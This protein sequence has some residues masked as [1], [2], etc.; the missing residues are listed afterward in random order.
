MGATTQQQNTQ[1]VQSTT[2]WAPAAGT[3]QGLLGNLSNINPNLTGA[4]TG[5]I[6]QLAALGQA[7]NPYTG[8]IGGVA[9]NLLGGG[10]AN[11]QGG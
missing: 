7:G 6:N 11:N 10:G 1:Q 4:Q 5:A 8:Q 9:G 2:P 3:I